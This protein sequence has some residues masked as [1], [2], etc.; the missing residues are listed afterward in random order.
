MRNL[1]SILAVAYLFGCGS[2][3]CLPEPTVDQTPPRI[4]LRIEYSESD[5][6]MAVVRE[7][8]DPDSPVTLHGRSNA[9][10]R[11]RFTATDPEGLRE[12]LPGITVTR[13]V[14]VGIDREILRIPPVTARCPVANLTSERMIPATGEARTVILTAGAENWNG[15]R[16]AIEPVMLRLE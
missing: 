12:L 1:F 6:G 9:P 15:T 4:S 10:V 16:T 11:V 7:I 5:T 13:T 3:E 8:T 2:A 14:A